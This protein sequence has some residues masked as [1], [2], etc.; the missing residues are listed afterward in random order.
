MLNIDNNFRKKAKQ[1]ERNANDVAKLLSCFASCKKDNPQ[2]FSDFQLD[3]KGKILSIFWSHAS[4][5]GD[6]MDFADAVTFD[7]THKTNLY[8]KPLGIQR[9]QNMHGKRRATSD[10]DKYD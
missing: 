9:L 2:F 8:E 6:Y 1:R 4:Q 3:K 7:T 10:A 5:Q